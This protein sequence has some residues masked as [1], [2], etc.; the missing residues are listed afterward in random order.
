MYGEKAR[1]LVLL[2]VVL[3]S[4]M[5]APYEDFPEDASS[6]TFSCGGEWCNETW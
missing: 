4:T 3:G 2:A 1:I 6:L 5:C